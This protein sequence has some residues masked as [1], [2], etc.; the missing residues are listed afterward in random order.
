MIPPHTPILSRELEARLPEGDTQ[1]EALLLMLQRKLEDLKRQLEE[2]EVEHS[3]Q[4]TAGKLPSCTSHFQAL[5]I[6]SY[7]QV[8]PVWITFGRLPSLAGFLSFHISVAMEE[9]KE[10]LEQLAEVR[11]K[12]LLQEQEHKFQQELQLK[13]VHL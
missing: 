4:M 3:Q 1:H 12:S 11:L 13:V 7:I 6:C 10:K 2:K 8:A 5:C 9:Q